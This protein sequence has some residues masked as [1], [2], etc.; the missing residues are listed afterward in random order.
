[1]YYSWLAVNRGEESNYQA[2][3]TYA[4]DNIQGKRF[5]FVSNSSTS[6][7]RVPSAGI[8][9][10]FSTQEKWAT[11]TSGDLIEGGSDS[12]FTDVQFGG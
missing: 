6:G 1:V 9:N 5:S 12:F 3:G 10:Y 7:F 4:I 8:I 11:L 2:S